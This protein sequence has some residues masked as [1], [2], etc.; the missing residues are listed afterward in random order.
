MNFIVSKILK[1]LYLKGYE[2]LHE[3]I[4][5]GGWI[6]P[7][8]NQA[9]IKNCKI[10]CLGRPNAEYF[11]YRTGNTCACYVEKDSC[12]QRESNGFNSYRIV[13][14]GTFLFR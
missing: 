4:C 10:E 9:S 11:A 13:K 5:A 8:T 12:E 2:L 14:N 3:G 6:T 1:I 7:N